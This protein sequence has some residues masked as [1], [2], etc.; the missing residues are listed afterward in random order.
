MIDRPFIPDV[1][2]A[3]L[4]AL[5]ASGSALLLLLVQDVFGWRE[6]V[7]EPA[8]VNDDNWTSSASAGTPTVSTDEP[9]AQERQSALRDLVTPPRPAED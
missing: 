8:H 2:D 1:R 6:R 4:E 5:F 9:E 3:I 7:N